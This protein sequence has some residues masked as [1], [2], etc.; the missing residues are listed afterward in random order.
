MSRTREGKRETKERERERERRRNERETGTRE[1]ERRGAG[2]RERRR[3]EREKERERRRNE[4]E[5]RERKRETRN[6]GWVGGVDTAGGD[7]G[8]MLVWREREC[9]WERWAA[10]GWYLW[11]A[12]DLN[13]LSLFAEHRIG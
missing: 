9:M 10:G 1:K 3:N 12:Y 7:L 2:R 5:G 13:C 11:L 8:G 4:R 6:E